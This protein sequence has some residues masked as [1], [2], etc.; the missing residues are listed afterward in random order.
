MFFIMGVSSKQRQLDFHQTIICSRC[1]Q[2]GHY[3]VYME[4]MYFSFFFIPL[5]KW[6]KKY[7][8]K[9]SCCGSLYTINKELGSAIEKGERVTIRDEDLQLFRDGQWNNGYRCSQCGAEG[10]NDYQYCP[11]CGKELR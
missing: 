10:N 3:E 5:F 8:V 2:Y 4:Y 7:Y 11:H 6:N 1:G 9:S